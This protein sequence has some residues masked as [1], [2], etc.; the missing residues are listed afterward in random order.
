MCRRMSI[1]GVFSDSHIHLVMEIFTD[2]CNFDLFTLK[3]RLLGQ[4]S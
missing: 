1:S 2:Y 3:F 4:V